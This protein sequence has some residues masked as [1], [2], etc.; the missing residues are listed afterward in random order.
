M[1]CVC[2]FSRSRTENPT[3]D[4]THTRMPD[5]WMAPTAAAN[6]PLRDVLARVQEISR[7]LD[8]K[9]QQIRVNHWVRKLQTQPT[10]NPTWTKNVAEYATTLLQMLLDGVRMGHI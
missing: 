3:R 4:P 10:S 2:G 5:C 9:H 8:S 6:D 1:M 7:R